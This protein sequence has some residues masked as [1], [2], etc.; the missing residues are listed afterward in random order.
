MDVEICAIIFISWIITVCKHAAAK[1]GVLLETITGNIFR[2][3]ASKIILCA[4]EKYFFM[5]NNFIA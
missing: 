1:P 5:C 3:K 4:K 2:E